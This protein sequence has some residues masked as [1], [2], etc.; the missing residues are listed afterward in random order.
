MRLLIGGAP[1]KF[2]HLK[3]FVD[4]LSKIDIQVKLVSDTDFKDGFPSKKISNWF[5]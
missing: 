1:S 4:S 2:F 5:Q 3:E